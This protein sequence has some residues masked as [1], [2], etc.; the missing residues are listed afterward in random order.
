VR[1]AVEIRGLDGLRKRFAALG[2]LKDLQPALRAEAEA[3]AAEAKARLTERDPNSRL[4]RSIKIMELGTEGQPAYAVGTDEPAGFFLEFGTSRMRAS[5]WLVPALHSRL[6]G[7]NHA[8]RK[9]IAA[10]LKAAAKV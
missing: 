3:V 6:P 9:V 4:A 5:P 1:P 8:V 2:A 10:A 7:I